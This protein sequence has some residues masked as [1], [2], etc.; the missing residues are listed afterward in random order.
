MDDLPHDVFADIW[1]GTDGLGRHLPDFAECGAPRADRFVG[2]FY[3]ICHTQRS[4]H[5]P[6]DV[7][8][9]IAA[10]P[11]QPA[12]QPNSSHYWGEPELGYY[13]STDRWVIRRHA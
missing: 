2:I 13:I 8:K 12:F 9:L 1:A 11:Q 3:F 5:L 4:P 6:L 10:N 7:S